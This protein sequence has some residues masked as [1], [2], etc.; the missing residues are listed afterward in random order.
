M[1]GDLSNYRK[2]Y[3]KD[4]LRKFNTSDNPM[5][6]FQKWF[7]EADSFEGIREANAMSIATLG[8]DGYPKSRVVL[9]KRSPDLSV[10]FLAGTGKADHYK[11]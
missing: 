2:D 5:E 8:L 3:E 7:F 4:E 6:L 10:I 1:E 9:L 11:R